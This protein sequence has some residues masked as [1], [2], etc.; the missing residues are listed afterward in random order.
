MQN[1]ILYTKKG[2]ALTGGS[3]P[4]TERKK[5]LKAAKQL[6]VYKRTPTGLSVDFSAETLQAR[7]GWHNIFKTHE[8]TYNQVPY[9]ARLSFSFEG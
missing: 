9:P 8:E 6:D 2:V 5:I 7:S 4:K 3:E 1:T